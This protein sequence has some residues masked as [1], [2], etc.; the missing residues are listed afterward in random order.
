MPE[1]INW[2]IALNPVNWFIVA[3]MLLIA[4][5]ALHILLPQNPSTQASN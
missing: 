3:L 2:K 1:I 4:G 5:F